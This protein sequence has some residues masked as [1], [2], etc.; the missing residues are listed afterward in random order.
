MS[1]FLRLS[2]GLHTVHGPQMLFRGHQLS[3][4]SQSPRKFFLLTALPLTCGPDPMSSFFVYIRKQSG[5]MCRSL[6]ASV[7]LSLEL[8]LHSA[9]PILPPCHPPAHQACLVR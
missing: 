1:A 5:W 2:S 4:H 3:L 6:L 8:V 7:S 9:S